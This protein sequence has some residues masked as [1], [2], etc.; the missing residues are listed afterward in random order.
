MQARTEADT[1]TLVAEPTWLLGPVIFAMAHAHERDGAPTWD[2]DPDRFDDFVDR[3]KW[4]EKGMRENERGQ[5]VP[6]I[7]SKLTGN[8]WRLIQDL[9]EEDKARLAKS[10]LWMG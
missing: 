1:P 4:Y 9:S 2:N 8:T 6:R 5:A 10:G 3:A 7:I